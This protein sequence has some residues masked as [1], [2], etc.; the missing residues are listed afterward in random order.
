MSSFFSIP[1]SRDRLSDLFSLITINAK[2]RWPHVTYL[3]NSDVAWRLP[4]SAPKE[5][6]RLWYDEEGIAAF[7]WFEPNGPISFDVR[8]GLD[9]H[10]PICTDLIAWLEIR[11]R[12]FPRLFPWLLSLK[13][14][15][16]W[17]NALTDELAAR[18]DPRMW[19]QVSALDKDE[20]RRQFLARMGF[21]PTEHFSY[22]LTRSLEDEIPE[23]ELP[24][25]YRLRSVEEPDFE[26]R[27]A[28]HRD[29]WFKS[30]FTLEQYLR[31]RAVDNFEPSL[32][33]VAE[34]ANG[35]F[36][37]YCIGWVDRQL[38]IGDFEPVG[39]RPA[40]R[41][42]GLGQAVN[43]EGLRRMKAMGMHSAKIGTAGF[44]DRAFGLYT[45]C[46]FK[47]IDKDR[48]WVKEIPE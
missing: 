32:D 13:S 29:A 39:T 1:F 11:R 16:D 6:I 10:N 7:A 19:L 34:D 48:T 3:M 5:N 46:G 36:G 24:A 28:T 20:E 44:N 2:A 31:I 47:L 17:E 43:Y 14:M 45:S 42:L 22:A 12:D 41:R 4:G 26:E 35:K 21:E 15:R 8:V 25:G 40:Y 27:V 30:G 18:P 9:F 23:P 38:G 37:S 33:I